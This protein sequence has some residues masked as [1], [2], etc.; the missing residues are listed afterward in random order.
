MTLPL[1]TVRLVDI[2]AQ[3]WRN[4]GGVTRELLA[5][6]SQS[7]WWVRVSIATIDRSGPFSAFPDV[8]RW[9]AV[10]SG[11][12]VRLALADGPHHVRQGD[13]P[14]SFNGEDAPS[15]DLLEGSSIDL[16][17]M[18]KRDAG[19][20]RMQRALAGS[21]VEGV[22]R[23][24]GVY[25]AEA[26][27]LEVDSVAIALEAGTL[28]WSDHPAPSTWRLKSTTSAWWLTLNA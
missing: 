19:T 20:A 27:A 11:A 1:Q 3:P 28:L 2:P 23:W 14:V 24:R 26:L 17:L 12:G 16:N 7:D 15:C 13:K 4:G 21:T 10:L 25:A 22:T 9:F 6:P 8:Q 5:W 18:A